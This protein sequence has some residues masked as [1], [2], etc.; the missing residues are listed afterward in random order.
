KSPRTVTVY[1]NCQRVNLLLNDQLIASQKPDSGVFTENLLHPPFT[2]H[3]IPWKPGK[4]KAIGYINGK[5]AASHIRITPGKAAFIDL[6]F[7]L[8]DAAIANGEDMFF[9]YASVV[10]ENGTIVRDEETEI[11]FHVT[12][13]GILISP[14]Q[15]E[16]ETGTATV[17]IRTTTQPGQIVIK[18][19]T[20]GLKQSV[21]SKNCIKH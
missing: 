17:L 14:E 7:D 10:D 3:N 16:T 2:F 8:K 20:E 19:E 18:A 6:F 15:V 5:E 1:S 9:V 12:G 13:S 11:S 4:L 21:I